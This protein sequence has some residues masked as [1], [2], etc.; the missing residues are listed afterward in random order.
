V[1]ALK[2]ATRQ[3]R[4]SGGPKLTPANEPPPDV[5]GRDEEAMEAL[6][7]VAHALILL[8][9]HGEILFDTL[10]VVMPAQELCDI[11]HNCDGP[12]PI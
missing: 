6:E 2:Q 4:E 7:K 9:E 11:Q 12:G 5:G 1:Q 8:M 3:L 10:F